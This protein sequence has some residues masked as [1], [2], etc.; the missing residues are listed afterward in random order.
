MGDE[1]EEVEV[2]ALKEPVTEHGGLMAFW[3]L[4]TH[5]QKIRVCPGAS[6]S[7]HENMT[8]SVEVLGAMALAT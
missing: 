1:F 3:V 4:S 8:Q 2:S 7:E 6:T 5:S